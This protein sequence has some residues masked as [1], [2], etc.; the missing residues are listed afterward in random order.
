MR[1]VQAGTVAWLETSFF[2]RFGV[3]TIPATVTDDVYCETTETLITDGAS[4]T[5]AAELEI[6]FT[7]AET[8]LQDATNDKEVRRVCV[9]SSYG[10]GDSRTDNFKFEVVRQETCQ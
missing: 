2:D 1:Q 9:H 3:A 4:A 5:P 8:A 7:S 6:A 10:A